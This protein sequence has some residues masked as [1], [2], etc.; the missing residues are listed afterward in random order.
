[1]RLRVA[2]LTLVGSSKYFDSVG[3]ETPQER[4]KS[5][6]VLCFVIRSLVWRAPEPWSSLGAAHD[7]VAGAP[8]RNLRRNLQ[9]TS[10]VS[11]RND[12]LYRA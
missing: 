6:I 3:L 5:S 2:G 8:P 11:T 4:A 10:V 1:M 9:E 7:P 12:K